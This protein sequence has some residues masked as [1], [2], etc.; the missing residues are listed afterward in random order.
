MTGILGE[1]CNKSQKVL[2]GLI[3]NTAEQ[4][5]NNSVMTVYAFVVME[6]CVAISILPATDVWLLQDNF[7]NITGDSYNSLMPL[8]AR[9]V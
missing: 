1:S 6:V 7:F 8:R 5:A 2:T 3:Y 4:S 9:I